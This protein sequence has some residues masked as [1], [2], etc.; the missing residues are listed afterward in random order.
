MGLVEYLTL[1]TDAPQY[2]PFPRFL[3]DMDLSQTAKLVYAILYDRTSLSKKNGWIDEQGRVYI[4]FSL[5][6]IMETVHKSRTPVKNA[7]RELYN[8]GLVERKRNYS[9]ANT[10]YVKLPADSQENGQVMDE[11][12]TVTGP[13]SRPAEGLKIDP[14]TDQEQP[15]C[16]SK[17]SPCVGLN[18]DL[19]RVQKQPSNQQSNNQLIEL[20]NRTRQQP[21]AELSGMR[22]P[23]D[24]FSEFAQEQAPGNTELLEALKSF[25]ENRQSIA[26]ANRKKP[27]TVLAAKKICKE[28]LRLADAKGVK[29]RAGYMALCL[30]KSTVVGW[31][32]VYPQEYFTDQ[33]PVTPAGLDRLHKS[34]ERKRESQTAPA[35]Q[36]EGDFHE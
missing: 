10:I 8:S 32:S 3:L 2:I 29:D 15:L 27:W 9:T 16:G 24:I 31:A 22:T 35:A 26:R 12:A 33:N 4:I 19:T 23:L 14:T 28:L 6:S 13:E 5:E 7:M 21:A 25:D 30:D 20:T 36:K 1:D 34:L 18:S 11:N 17:N